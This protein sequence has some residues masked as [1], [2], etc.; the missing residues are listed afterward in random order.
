MTITQQR[1]DAPIKAARPSGEIEQALYDERDRLV[2]ALFQYGHDN[3]HCSDL[4]NALRTVYPDRSPWSDG[5][6]RD[7]NGL[8]YHG[9]DSEGYDTDGYHKQT[10]YNRE[11]RNCSGRTE[12]EDAEYNRREREAYEA[13]RAAEPDRWRAQPGTLAGCTCLACERIRR[14]IRG[15]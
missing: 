10:G 4:L 13:R 1:T 5:V 12:A 6:W 9:W 2:N 15:V 7:S 11:G 3:G 8:D 14:S